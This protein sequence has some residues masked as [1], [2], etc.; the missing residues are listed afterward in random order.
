[1]PMVQSN[2]YQLADAFIH[3]LQPKIDY[4]LNEDHDAVWLTLHGIQRAERFF[5][6]P[7]L[8]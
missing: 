8:L 5:R 3:I 2:L 1:M 4:K 6:I 7:D